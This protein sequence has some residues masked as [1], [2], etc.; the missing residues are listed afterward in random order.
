MWVDCTGSE[1]PFEGDVV[2]SDGEADHAWQGSCQP[3]AGPSYASVPGQPWQHEKSKNTLWPQY[4]RKGVA[5]GIVDGVRLR[6]TP[7]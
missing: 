6:S 3:L 7:E 4:E 5:I 1:G 2:N